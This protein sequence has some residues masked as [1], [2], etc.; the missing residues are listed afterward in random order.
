MS[1]TAYHATAF[2][3]GAITGTCTVAGVIILIYRR[4]TVGPVFSATTG[5]QDHVRAAGRH[6]AGVGHDRHRQPHRPPA[7]LPPDPR[8]LG[9][10]RSSTSTPTRA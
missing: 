7:R 8:P 6:P 3:L 10:G 1:E 5:R 4:R 2:T 9:S